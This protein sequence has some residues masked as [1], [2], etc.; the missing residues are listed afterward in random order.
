MRV[1]TILPV[2]LAAATTA[3]AKTVRVDVGK[4]GLSFTPDVIKADKGD[5]LDFHF[6]PQKHSVVLGDKDKAC[7][8]AASNVFYSGFIPSSSGEAVEVT[9]T[10]PMYIYC[11]AAK[12]CQGGMAAVVNGDKDGLDKYKDNAAKASEN[13]SPKE[14]TGGKVVS[15]GSGGSSSG[16]SSETTAS[17]TSSGAEATSTTKSHSSGGSKTTEAATSSGGEAATSSSGAASISTSP[18]STAKPA[19]AAGFKASVAGVLAAA[20]GVAAMML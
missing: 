5:T 10:D 18:S 17:A 13:V 12:H 1:N 11:S 3:S 7:S 8:P 16:G 9:S 4:D 2:A 14:V 20:G 19:A 6:Y 15:G